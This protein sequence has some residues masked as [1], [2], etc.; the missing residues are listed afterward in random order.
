MTALVGVPVPGVLVAPGE[1]WRAVQEQAGPYSLV[2]LYGASVQTVTPVPPAALP[3]VSVAG[4]LAAGHR[5]GAVGRRPALP[6]R[7]RTGRGR[8]QAGPLGV[9]LLPALPALVRGGLPGA[10]RRAHLADGRAVPAVA[11]GT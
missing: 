6:D 5:G 8:E 11:A 9:V 1:V 2:G 10:D 7:E 4:G 3:A